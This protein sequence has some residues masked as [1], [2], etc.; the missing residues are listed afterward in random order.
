MQET[1]HHIHSPLGNLNGTQKTIAVAIGLIINR[2][3]VLLGKRTSGYYSGF[4]EYPGGK[5]EPNENSYQALVR[6]MHEELG[7]QVSNATEVLHIQEQ[8]PQTTVHLQAWHINSYE[9]D[10]VANEQQE[11]QW[12]TITRLRS[13]RVIPTNHPITSFLEQLVAK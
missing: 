12:C 3:K 9:E 5:I 7:I 1:P 11:L 4:W 10:I 13:I 2:D 6:E 8:H